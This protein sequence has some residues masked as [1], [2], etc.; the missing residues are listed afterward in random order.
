MKTLQLVVFLVLAVAVASHEQLRG[1]R[2]NSASLTVD[3]GRRARKLLMESKKKKKKSPKKY[4]TS[5]ELE[6]MKTCKK[7]VNNEACENM[8]GDIYARCI[9]VD[10]HVHSDKGVT[11]PDMEAFAREVCLEK[12]MIFLGGVLFDPKVKHCVDDNLIEVIPGTGEPGG[13]LCKYRAT[14][15]LTAALSGIIV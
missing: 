11:A 9:V 4:S 8:F 13:D 7:M 6:L 14:P 12:G 10:A 3:G 15:E 1:D 5:D 2:R